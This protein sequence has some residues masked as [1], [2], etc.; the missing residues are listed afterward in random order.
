MTAARTG[1]NQKDLTIFLA[2]RVEGLSTKL[3]KTSYD[4]SAGTAYI[5]YNKVRVHKDMILGKVNK[6]FKTIM[7]NFNHERWMINVM[8]LAACRKGIDE[9]YKWAVLRKVFGKPLIEQPVIRSKLAD[10]CAN[11]EAAGQ[12]LENLT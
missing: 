11:V 1:P 10:M 12:W 8:T 9:C 2:E 6:G 7:F 3:I 5:T 4:G